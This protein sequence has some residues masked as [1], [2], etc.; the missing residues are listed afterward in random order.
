MISKDVEINGADATAGS[1]FI[2][3]RITGKL[4]PKKAAIDIFR[5]IADVIQIEKIPFPVVS[6]TKLPTMMPIKIPILLP[7]NNSLRIIPK[8][9]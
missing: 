8:N 7:I 2:C 4:A 6:Q 9:Y 5:K 1:I 3:F